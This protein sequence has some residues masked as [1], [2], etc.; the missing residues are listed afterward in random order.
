MAS[1]KNRPALS[2]GAKGR[3]AQGESQDAFM[4][5]AHVLELSWPFFFLLSSQNFLAKSV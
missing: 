2:L 4:A 1:V 5:Q 3:D